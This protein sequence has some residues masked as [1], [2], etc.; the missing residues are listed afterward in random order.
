MTEHLTSAPIGTTS[1]EC[2]PA[3]R[4]TKSLLGYGVIAGPLYVAV[5]LAQ[6][7]TREGFDLGVHQWSLLANGGPGWIQI[8]NFA[9]TGLMV[10]AFAMGLRRALTPGPGARWAPRLVAVYGASLVAAGIF[11]ADPAL[12]FPVG[13]PEGPGEISWHGLLHFAAGGIGFTCLAIACIVVGR[14]YATEGA[15]GLAWFSRVTGV[16]FLA[17]FAMVASGAGSRTANLVF[18]AAVILIWVWMTTIA[19]NRYRRVGRTNPAD[20]TQN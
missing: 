3:D 4:V 2:A 11:R 9:I 12:G 20:T 8:A 1:A 15:R 6:A 14:R 7:F 10:I 17:G 18:T 16:V 19:L 13:T 5:A